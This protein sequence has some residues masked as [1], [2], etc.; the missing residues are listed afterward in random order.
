MPIKKPGHTLR[1]LLDVPQPGTQPRLRRSQN[2]PSLLKLLQASAQATYPRPQQGIQI[3]TRF[4][5]D[6]LQCMVQLVWVELFEKHRV[7]K[8]P[9]NRALDGS[10][11]SQL[12]E[13]A[14]GIHR[15]SLHFCSRI[16]P[17]LLL[18]KLQIRS[19]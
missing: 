15:Q 12:R 2:R 3:L 7:I 11:K 17:A 18:Q 14:A 6:V 5:D 19:R 8:R 16:K 13:L 10:W 4:T 1:S 9:C